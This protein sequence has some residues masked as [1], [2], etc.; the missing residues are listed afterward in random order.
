MNIADPDSSSALNNAT[1]LKPLESFDITTQTEVLASVIATSG[2]QNYSFGLFFGLAAALVAGSFILP[3]ITGPIL[4]LVLQS[5]YKYRTKWRLLYPF[6]LLLY[7]AGIYIAIPILVI[8]FDTDGLNTYGYRK[9]NNITEYDLDHWEIGYGVFTDGSDLTLKLKIIALSFQLLLPTIAFLSIFQGLGPFRWFKG[10]GGKQDLRSII[11]R[12]LFV[13]FSSSCVLI[14]FGLWRSINI[15]QYEYVYYDTT[16][17][18]EYNATLGGEYNATLA[19]QNNATL[20]AE[21]VAAYNTYLRGLQEDHLAIP[22]GILPVILLL[23]VYYGSSIQ[24]WC[25]QRWHGLWHSKSE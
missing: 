23:W 5:T 22:I 3:V 15:S 11:K 12:L 20:V 6:L 24:K 4:R 17:G 19:A 21:Y 7:I 14:L 16:L 18:G 1:K 2:S 25:V 10:R 13:I 8:K 9:T